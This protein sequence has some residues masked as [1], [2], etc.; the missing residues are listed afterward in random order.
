MMLKEQDLE[1]ENGEKNVVEEDGDNEDVQTEKV[2][3]VGRGGKY[4]K[5]PLWNNVSGLYRTPESS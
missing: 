2:G 3:E 5:R 4:T 1:T